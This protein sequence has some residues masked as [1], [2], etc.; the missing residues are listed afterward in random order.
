MGRSKSSLRKGYDSETT[1]GGKM[2]R[3]WINEHVGEV[4]FGLGETSS[5]QE[6]VQEE[7]EFDVFRQL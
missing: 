3:K 1:L 7:E 2:E 6:K 4:D 5:S